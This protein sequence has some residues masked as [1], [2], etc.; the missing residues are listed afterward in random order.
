MDESAGIVPMAPSARLRRDL[1]RLALDQDALRRLW[2]TW[3]LTAPSF[4]A[5]ALAPGQGFKGTAERWARAVTNRRVGLAVSGGGAASYRVVPLIRALHRGK[6]PIDVVSA[7]SGG[8]LLGA[9]YCRYG[10]DGLRRYINRGRLYYALNY[11]AVLSPWL[12]ESAVDWDTGPDDIDQLEVRFVPLTTALPKNSPPL[13]SAVVRGTLGEGVRA[14]GAAPGLY[15]RTWKRGVIYSDGQSASPLPARA[16]GEFGADLILACNAIPGPDRRNPLSDLP[17]GEFVFRCTPLGRLLDAWVA[18]AFLLE[19]I[20]Q[21]AALD[22]HAF[23]EATPVGTPLLDCVR[24]DR[25]KEFVSIAT[26]DERVQ[27]GAAKCINEWQKF[28]VL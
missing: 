25:A 3:P 1:C 7:I 6:V 21:Q 17:G 20:S 24:F 12:L 26:K 9:Y 11:L 28:M 5:A 18:G 2:D 14:S 16:V 22:A 4:A 13:A 10:L 19:R 8:A 27:R 23:V 15:A